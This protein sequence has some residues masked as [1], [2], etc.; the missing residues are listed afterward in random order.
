MS[1]GMVKCYC[2]FHKFGIEYRKRAVAMSL[3]S[4]EIF[5]VVDIRVAKSF[6]NYWP[7]NIEWRMVNIFIILCQQLV[8]NAIIFQ[9]QPLKLS[10]TTIVI[11]SKV[12]LSP[13]LMIL[14]PLCSIY[15]ITSIIIKDHFYPI[16]ISELAAFLSI[17]QYDSTQY[18]LSSKKMSYSLLVTSK[19]V[20]S[21]SLSTSAPTN[22]LSFAPSSMASNDK[23][24]TT[25]FS[26]FSSFDLDYFIY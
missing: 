20:L 13:I 22:S 2:S 12:Q 3:N 7:N 10:L 14:L 19:D 16:L 8:H 1:R 24:I 15:Q 6:V 9:S 26:I 23:E 17:S 18:W 11:I 5:I 4:L 25:N 21:L